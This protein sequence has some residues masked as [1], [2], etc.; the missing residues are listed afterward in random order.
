MFPGSSGGGSFPSLSVLRP[1]GQGPTSGAFIFPGRLLATLTGT[2]GGAQLGGGASRWVHLLPIRSRLGRFL[3]SGGGRLLLR[4]SRSRLME[5]RG[6]GYSWLSPCPAA[7]TNTGS[8]QQVLCRGCRQCVHGLEWRHPWWR[9][10]WVSCPSHRRAGLGL[11]GRDHGHIAHCGWCPQGRCWARSLVRDGG[12]PTPLADSEAVS[13]VSH[14]GQS[15]QSVQ[16]TNYVRL[17]AAHC[18]LR[19]QYHA[20]GDILHTGGPLGQTIAQQVNRSRPG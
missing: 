3:P 9:V 5:A 8:C 7:P 16:H 20:R 6:S 14:Q 10:T 1:S 17:W 2:G 15:L 12:A 19:R 11:G 13:A 4:H 18:R